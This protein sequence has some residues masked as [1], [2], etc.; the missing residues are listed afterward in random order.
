MLTENELFII[1]KRFRDAGEKV[2]KDKNR[3]YPN[4]WCGVLSR[5]LGIW[6]NH[7]FPHEVFDYICGNRWVSEGYYY[8][9]GW[10]EFRNIIIDISADQFDDC[11]EPII[12]RK[13]EL[14]I[15]HSTFE[16]DQIHTRNVKTIILD[17]SDLENSIIEEAN[18][19][20]NVSNKNDIQEGK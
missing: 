14:S 9:H 20:I 3:F 8:S 1:A 10:I 19:L 18:K 12:I 17:N 11:N 16:I 7:N 13:K 6:L 5:S 4:G 15:F 2:A